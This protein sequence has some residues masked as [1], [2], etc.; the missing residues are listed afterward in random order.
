MTTTRTPEGIE[1]SDIV[2][3]RRLHRHYIGHTEKEAKEL[4]ARFIKG[5]NQGIKD[6]Q[7]EPVKE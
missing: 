7:K 1:V 6:A 5:L 3:G 4:F 2:N